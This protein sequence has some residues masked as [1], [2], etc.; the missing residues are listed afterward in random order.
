M[1]TAQFLVAHSLMSRSPIVASAATGSLSSGILWL[2]HEAFLKEDRFPSKLD[3]GCGIETP[4]HLV[5]AAGVVCGF[6]LWPIIELLVLGKQWLTLALRNRISG[7]S[8]DGKLY[9]VLS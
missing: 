6:I 3:F 7:L 2:L 9:R 5:F 1:L 4:N 8:L